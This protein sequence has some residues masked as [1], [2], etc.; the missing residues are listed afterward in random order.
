LTD[1]DDLIEHYRNREITR[2]EFDNRIAKVFG[3]T[4]QDEDDFE[5]LEAQIRGYEEHIRRLE[6]VLFNTPIGE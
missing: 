1:I 2:E 5:M 3:V 4:E 6:A